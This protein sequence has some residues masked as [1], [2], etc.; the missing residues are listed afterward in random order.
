MQ[1]SFFFFSY[2]FFFCHSVL[3]LN[4]TLRWFTR[5]SFKS[6]TYTTL[7]MHYGWNIA[8]GIIGTN[9]SSYIYIIF[10][11]VYKKYIMSTWL[12]RNEVFFWTLSIDNICF[13]TPRSSLLSW[14]VWTRSCFFFFFFFSLQPFGLQFLWTKLYSVFLEV[15][16]RLF[17]VKY[18]FRFICLVN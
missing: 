14:L 11:S 15:K 13:S 5:R 2:A 10:Y 18:K 17:F 9:I 7:Y 12:S 1:I 6:F 16:C 8:D 4:L 3:F